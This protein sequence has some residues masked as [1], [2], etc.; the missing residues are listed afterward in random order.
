MTKIT[1][2]LSITY[3]L[4]ND[5][6]YQEYQ[7]QLGDYSDTPGQREWFVIDQFIGHQNLVFLD[8]RAKLRV[9]ELT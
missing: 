7:E 4:S 9:E 2:T 3:D 8:K 1:V 6:L 5:E